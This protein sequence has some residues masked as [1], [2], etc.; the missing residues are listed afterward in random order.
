MPEDTKKD[1]PLLRWAKHIRQGEN[2]LAALALHEAVQ[3][4]TGT[5]V[6]ETTVRVQATP[7][8]YLCRMKSLFRLA[9]DEA[10]EEEVKG[11]EARNPG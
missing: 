8:E 6:G 5:K 11:Y 2:T 1:S 9:A 10:L 4:A 3:Q 7:R